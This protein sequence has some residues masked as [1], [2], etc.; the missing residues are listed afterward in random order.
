MASVDIFVAVIDGHIALARGHL[1]LSFA[2][3]RAPPHGRAALDVDDYRIPS[4]DGPGNRL[5]NEGDEVSPMPPCEFRT[6][7]ASRPGADG[8]R[9]DTRPCGR[10]WPRDS[11]GPTCRSARLWRRTCAFCSPSA[12]KTGRRLARGARAPLMRMCESAVQAVYS[13]SRM[14]MALRERP[15]VAHPRRVGPVISPASRASRTQPRARST[16]FSPA[17]S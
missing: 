15:P 1:A 9:P 14:R 4:P 17:A 10:G 16:P 5:T 2:G 6:Y 3:W 7:A 8:E 12:T 11:C 13:A